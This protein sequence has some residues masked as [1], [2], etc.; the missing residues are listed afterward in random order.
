M[1]SISVKTPIASHVLLSQCLPRRPHINGGTPHFFPAQTG[2][3]NSPDLPSQSNRA[4]PPPPMNRV[5]SEEH[6][7]A[8]PPPPPPRQPRKQSDST[9]SRSEGPP[10]ASV[11][12]SKG[13]GP[14]VPSFNSSDAP[15]IPSR[16]TT[17]STSLKPAK[18]P[19]PPRGPKPPVPKKAVNLT[20]STKSLEELSLAE[21][22]RKVG[23]DAPQLIEAVANQ[24]QPSLGRDLDMFVQLINCIITEAQNSSN[25]SSVQFKRCI[26]TLRSQVGGLT[27]VSFQADVNGV[28]KVIDM[29]ATK[30][31]QLSSHLQ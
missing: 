19:K 21:K 5:Q 16:P 3:K 14:P 8:V 7:P 26:T 29:L 6:P 22:I 31:Q 24:Q 11:T 25:D 13:E 30:T 9:P 20:K 12:P 18:A 4:L 28:T 17:G 23:T 1:D 10:V 2:N 27:D 15:P